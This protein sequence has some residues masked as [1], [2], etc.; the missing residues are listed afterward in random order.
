M[1]QINFVVYKN[2]LRQN[3]SFTTV[4]NLTKLVG[5]DASP[6]KLPS[7]KHLY[8]QQQNFKSDSASSSPQKMN[9]SIPS[10]SDIDL[11]IFLKL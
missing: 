9:Y 7:S 10:N 3:F 1:K 4:A 5:R 6:F 11:V 2:V 8:S